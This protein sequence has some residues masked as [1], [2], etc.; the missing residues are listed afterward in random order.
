MPS[1]GIRAQLRRVPDIMIAAIFAAALANSITAPY[2][3]WAHATWGAT[4]PNVDLRIENRSK[5]TAALVDVDC[6]AFDARGALVAEPSANL[7][8]LAPGEAAHTWATSDQ[9]VAATRFACQISVD[10]WLKPR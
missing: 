1:R 6:K 4:R 10:H 2:G 5:V 7:A 3:V 9:S 8:S